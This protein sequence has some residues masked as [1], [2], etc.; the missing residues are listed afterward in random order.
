MA[1][2]DARGQRVLRFSAYGTPIA[3]ITVDKE[4]HVTARLREGTKDLLTFDSA[5][6][7]ALDQI[8]RQVA[9]MEAE[10]ARRA[11]WTADSP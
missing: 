6:K 7:A 1:A 8:A 11:S 4:G 3:E 10:E 2:I 9:L 5:M